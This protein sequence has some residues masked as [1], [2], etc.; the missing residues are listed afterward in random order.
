MGMFL[1]KLGVV[2][3]IMILCLFKVMFYFLQWDSAPLNSP[4]FGEYALFFPTTQPACL[5]DGISL[6]NLKTC[7]TLCLRAAG[8]LT[9]GEMATQVSSGQIMV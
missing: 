6:T 2:K 8:T 5:S 7:G 1:F 3:I 4:P 9:T